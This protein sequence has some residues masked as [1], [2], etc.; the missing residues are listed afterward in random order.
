[1]SDKVVEMKHHVVLFQARAGPIR[2][3]MFH[4]LRER[5]AMSLTQASDEAG[6]NQ[7]NTSHNLRCLVFGRLITVGRQGKS[8]I[9]PTKGITLLPVLEIVANHLR[10]SAGSLLNCYLLGR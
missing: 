1:M 3:R 10:K 9:Y 2:V 5:A 8:R 4:A 7:T 6:L